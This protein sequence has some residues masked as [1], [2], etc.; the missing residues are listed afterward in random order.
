[1]QILWFSKYKIS[2]FSAKPEG[3]LKQNRTPD[4]KIT[5]YLHQWGI[6]IARAR[7]YLVSLGKR[8][9]MDSQSPNKL[10]KLICLASFY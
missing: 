9:Y 2:C 1:M 6:L 10:Q 5:N 8:V 4:F 7:F 3:S